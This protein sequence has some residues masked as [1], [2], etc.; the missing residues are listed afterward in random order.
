MAEMDV[1]KKKKLK[2]LMVI[3][4]ITLHYIALHYRHLADVM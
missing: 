2:I 4:V 3:D 1:I